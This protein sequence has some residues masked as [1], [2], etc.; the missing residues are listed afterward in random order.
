M[1]GRQLRRLLYALGMA[2][3]GLAAGPLQAADPGQYRIADGFSVYLGVLPAQMVAGHPPGHPEATM[4]DGAPA[5]E[6]SYHLMIAV[7]E[8]DSGARVSDLEATA[9]VSALGLVGPRRTLE[10]MEIAGAITFGNYFELSGGGPYRIDVEFR[11]VGA[12]EPVQ[13]RFEYAHP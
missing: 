13:V 6:H 11:R 2:L 7:F 9:R 10:P 12:A 1:A 4:H 5:G 8:A 3:T